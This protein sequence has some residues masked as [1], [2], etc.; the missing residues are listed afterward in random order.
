[1]TLPLT[2]TTSRLDDCGPCQ[3]GRDRAARLLGITEPSDAPISYARLLDCLGLDDALWCCR[4]EPQHASTWRRYS[5]WCARQ[6]QHLM[7]DL[8]SLAAIEAAERH[9]AGQATNRELAVVA[10]AAKSAAAWS[11]AAAAR[12]AMRQRQAAAFR[13]LVTTGTLPQPEVQP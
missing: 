12:S 4:A 7:S 11:A 3:S 6:V 8:R 10:A 1:M 13:Q 2:T 5:V 9:A